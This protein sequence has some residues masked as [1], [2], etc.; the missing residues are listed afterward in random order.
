MSRGFLN[1][2]RLRMFLRATIALAAIV[3]AANIQADEPSPDPLFDFKAILSEPLDAKVLEEKTP[4]AIVVQRV[5]FAGPKQAGKP[6]R[7]FG[8]LAYPRGGTKL[9]AVFWSQNG[10]APAGEYFPLYFARRGYACLNVT[11]DHTVWNSFAPFD[12][13]QP[14]SANLTQLA[15]VQMRG[16]TYLSKRREVDADRIGVAGGSYGGFFATL[17]AGA[18]PR[19]KAGLSFFGAGSHHLGTNLPQFTGLKTQRDVEVWKTTIDPTWRLRRR[20]VPF[21]WGVGSNDHWFHLPAIFDTYRQSSGEKGLAVAVPWGHAGPANMDDQLLTW[22]DIYLKKSRPALNRPGELRVET[23][24]GRL[25]GRFDWTGDIKASKAELVV[26]YGPAKPWHQWVHRGHFAFP[27]TIEK[28][29][30]A[31]EIPV[32]DPALDIF[33]FAILTDNNGAMVTTSPQT[34]RPAAMGIKTSSLKP[35]SLNGFPQ[36]DFEPDDVTFFQRSGLPFGTVDT[37]DK[38][39]G[40]QSI[41]LAAGQ[42]VTFKLFHVP[43]RSH[44]LRLFL[45]SDQ[46]A[47][48]SV[49]VNGLPPQNNH[50]AVVRM[51]RAANQP[52]SGNPNQS[53]PPKFGTRASTTNQWKPYTIKC[54]R[55]P[56]PIA[57]YELVI[58]APTDRTCWI[59]T[60][61]FEPE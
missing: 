50:S 51:L 28:Q 10:M 52:T 55:S 22:L 61:R 37:T 59:D 40:R 19:V 46:P 9:P 20:A 16:I 21:L 49:Q 7:V 45:K 23:R 8:I 5:E 35:E 13:A 41:R 18:D 24:D 54:S 56:E 57:G 25:Q 32:L 6:V 31:G 36:G 58:T 44:R 39:T 29:S 3:A 2:S 48:V 42:K 14:K 33:V 12:T 4:D 26:S 47:D 1:S 17:I 38:H 15:V 60:V 53:V 43:T 11:L 30:A 27:A 34:V